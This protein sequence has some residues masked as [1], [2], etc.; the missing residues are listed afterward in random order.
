[1]KQQSF[2]KWSKYYFYYILILIFCGVFILY[3]KHYVGNDSSL[4]GWLINYS[5][6]FVRRGLIGQIV[7]EFSYFFSIKLRI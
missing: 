5:G 2:D 6:G 3:H 7:L 4:S 1:M